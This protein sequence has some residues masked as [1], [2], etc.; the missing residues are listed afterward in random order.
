[1][2]SP[3]ASII[4]YEKSIDIVTITRASRHYSLFFKVIIY[5][6]IFKEVSKIIKTRE[7]RR[8]RVES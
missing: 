8:K 4:H 7:I 1:M 2:K 5:R 3:N 6:N